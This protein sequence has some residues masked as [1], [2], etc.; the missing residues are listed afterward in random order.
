[1]AEVDL[2]AFLEHAEVEA[3]QTER[4]DL[5]VHPDRDALAVPCDR[6]HR[7]R[8]LE[9][10]GGFQH[11]GGAA[12][13]DEVADVGERDRGELAAHL[14][15]GDFGALGGYF[16]LRFNGGDHVRVVEEAA[17]ELVG[18][19]L[20]VAGLARGVGGVQRGD[21]LVD[22]PLL[23]RRESHKKTKAPR[24]AQL[25]HYGR[26]DE[27]PDTSHRTR[28]RGYVKSVRSRSRSRLAS[29]RMSVCS[30]WVSSIVPDAAP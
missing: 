7:R 15:G 20:A 19:L 24:R 4:L 3:K 2:E 9:V 8:G 11:D 13:G 16:P 30:G 22:E 26:A 23:P 10:G 1:E 27:P 14:F 5:V 12:P 29:R 28:A 17:A 21:V 25:G 6:L 18:V